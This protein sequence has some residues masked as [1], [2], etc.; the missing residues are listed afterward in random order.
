MKTAIVAVIIAVA[1]LVSPKIPTVGNL[2]LNR[3]Q[4]DAKRTFPYNEVIARAW[5]VEAVLPTKS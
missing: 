5:F 2:N 4:T 1:F 3:I